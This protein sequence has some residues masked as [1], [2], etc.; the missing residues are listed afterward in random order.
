MMAYIDGN[1]A[2]IDIKASMALGAVVDGNVM[3]LENA[4]KQYY[5]VNTYELTD[6]RI[7]SDAK[8]MICFLLVWH[9]GYSITSVAK[10]YNIY[11]GYLKT[12][13]IDHYKN[14][15]LNDGYNDFVHGFISNSKGETAKAS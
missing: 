10:A 14:L 1:I 8:K 15:L 9:L 6:W 12:V 5:D 13:V 2:Q 7:D 4:V 3:R 11:R